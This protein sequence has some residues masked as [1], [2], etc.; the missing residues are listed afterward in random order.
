[1]RIAVVQNSVSAAPLAATGSDLIFSSV[2]LVPEGYEALGQV[3]VLRGDAV[4][5]LKSLESMARRNV[6]VLVLAPGSESDL[7]AEAVLE[8]AIKLSDAVAGLVLIVEDDGADPGQPGH[9]T[10]AI[11]MLGEVLAEA[12]GG[13]EVLTADI[14]L[15]VAQPMPHDPVPALPTILEQRLA[16]HEGRHLHTEYP[17]DS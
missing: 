7:Q 12:M 16:H 9:G 13:S 2:D 11:V 4:F 3:A 6:D 1:M 15:P 10:S 14:D 17:S 8:F 5:D